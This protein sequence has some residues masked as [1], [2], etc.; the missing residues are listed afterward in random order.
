MRHKILWMKSLFVNHLK[1]DINRASRLKI[2]LG[3]HH[4]LFHRKVRVKAFIKFY[5]SSIDKN[6]A[7]S[8]LNK[9]REDVTVRNLNV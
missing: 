9:K 5:L 7:W 2:Q 6:K 3:I 8:R 1:K 4:L